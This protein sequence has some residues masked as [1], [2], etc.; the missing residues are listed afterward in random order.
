MFPGTQ[1]E[2]FEGVSVMASGF[3]R[4]PYSSRRFPAVTHMHRCANRFMTV[5]RFQR[6]AVQGYPCSSEP[7]V[8]FVSGI[9]SSSAVGAA[10][11]SPIT[12]MSSH[13]E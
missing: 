13:S 9:R 12:T 2:P 3:V 4:K 1:P 6:C 8:H 7:T 11:E 10:S 5:F